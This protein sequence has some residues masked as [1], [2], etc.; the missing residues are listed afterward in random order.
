M[1]RCQ[2]CNK[3]MVI[4]FTCKCCKIYCLKHQ[5]PELHKCTYKEELFKLLTVL[6]KSKI[7]LI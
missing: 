6:P 2:E 3:K 5:L 7:D 4:H 1:L